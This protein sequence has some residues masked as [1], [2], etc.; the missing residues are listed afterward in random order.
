MDTDVAAVND[1][2]EK[3]IG[4][5]FRVANRLGCGFLEKVY[6]NA[7]AIEIRKLGLVAEQQ[8]RFTV[9]YDGVAVGDY[10]CDLVV[11]RRI[12]VE[13][14]SSRALEPVHFAQCLNYLKATGLPLALLFHF[15]APRLVVRR[16]AND[17]AFSSLPCPSA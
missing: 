15:G 2:S 4:C 7:P 9:L 3:I 12:I 16:I 5:A 6:E 8:K 14:K 11:D 17:P 1:V 10:L 13:T